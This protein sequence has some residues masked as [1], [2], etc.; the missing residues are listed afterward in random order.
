V[1]DHSSGA[2]VAVVD[3]DPSILKSLEYLLASADHHVRVFAAAGDMLESDCLATIDCL[4]SDID[5]PVTDGF[6]LLRIVHAARPELPILLITGHPEMLNGR[7]QIAVG[8]YRLFKKPFA[9]QELLTAV[10]DA[11][12]KLQPC[13]DPR[14]DP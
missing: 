6:E 11:L 14:R 3:D 1:T 12:E 4:I 2:I 9:G 13:V 7:S 5:M 8:H 10:S